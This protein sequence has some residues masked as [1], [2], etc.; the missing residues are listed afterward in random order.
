MRIWGDKIKEKFER[1]CECPPHTKGNFMQGLW[2]R[3]L[4]VT[5]RI[6]T[7][8]VAGYFSYFILQAIPFISNDGRS[9]IS[10]A[11]VVFVSVVGKW[12]LKPSFI[13]GAINMSVVF[14]ATKDYVLLSLMGV[15]IIL[16][17]IWQMD[18]TVKPV[19]KKGKLKKNSLK[20]AKNVMEEIISQNA[21]KVLLR[22]YSIWKKEC[23]MPD[24]EGLLEVTKLSEVQLKRAL[25]YCKEKRFVDI[26]IR[27]LN[28]GDMEYSS[29]IK[30]ITAAGIDIIEKPEDEKGE[31]PFNV[32]FNFNNEFKIDSIIKGEAKAF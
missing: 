18:E 1:W 17:E 6:I 26:D 13:L 24:R 20:K 16:S 8:A 7:A 22:I 31:K 27:T 29:W 5:I 15:L 3:V 11:I 14:V 21:G 2:N 23:K 30:D 4:K 25:K 19:E 9:I 32:I 28:N 10:M 12:K